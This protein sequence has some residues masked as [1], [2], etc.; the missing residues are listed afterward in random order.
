MTK[1]VAFVLPSFAAGGSERVVLTLAKALAR[2]RFAPELVVFEGSGP[3][4]EARP[5]DIPLTDLGQPRLRRALWHLIR[6]LRAARP[7]IVISSLGYVNLALLA[8][9]SALPPRT[10]LVVREANTPSQSLPHGPRP[11]TTALAYRLLYP[12]ADAVLCQHHKTLQEMA[13]RFRVPE[14]RLH[15]LPNPVEV[16]RLRA[17]AATPERVPGPGRRFVAVGRLTRQKG[18]DRLLELFAEADADDHLLI[19]GEGPERA[20][21]AAMADERVTLPGHEPNPWPQMAGA[22]ALLLPSRWE[23]LANVALEALACGTPVIATPESGGIAELA[24]A[25]PDGA[26]TI[27]P[28]GEPFARAMRAAK[29][30]PSNNLLPPHYDR[31]AVATKLMAILD[32]C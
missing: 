30:G 31:D 29:A 13:S 3:L 15:F 14:E 4:A 2:D 18:F 32:G 24:A 19:L 21:L 25:A 5:A 27:A 8:C 23:G 22:D 16:A 12:T 9:R 1:R 28:W 6:A 20:A 10:K 7:D 17:T 11:G 26:V